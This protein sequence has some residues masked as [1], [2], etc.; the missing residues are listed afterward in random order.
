MSLT[1]AEQFVELC[2]IAIANT[3]AR[4]SIR[5]C[6]PAFDDLFRYHTGE[7]LGRRLEI[8]A[9]LDDEVAAALRRAHGKPVSLTARARRSDGTPIDFDVHFVPKA[10]TGRFA[11]V[12]GIFRDLTSLRSAE[13]L[14][15]KITQT[16]IEEQERERSRIARH[17]HDDV[18]QRLTVLQIGIERL[19]TDLPSTRASLRAQLEKLQTEA[20]GVSAS[21]RALS[22]DV[23]VPT[24][25]LIAIDKVLERVCGDVAAQRGIR[26]H[27]T[28]SHVPRS[29]PHDVSLAL[30]R[31]VQ[32]AVNLPKR[33]SARDAH[34]AHRNDGHGSSRHP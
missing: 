2:P 12:W 15:S 14:L 34:H 16:M 10:R 6:N 30:F 13:A 3:D 27:F 1:R 17:L 21:V 20:K 4:H 25:G 31:V 11:G 29:V 8:V 32:E 7:A 26:I 28:S 5:H 24:V 23:E 18:A 19:K 22:L 33:S 9:G